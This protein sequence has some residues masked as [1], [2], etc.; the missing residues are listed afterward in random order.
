MPQPQCICGRR[1]SDTKYLR[2]HETACPTV[3]ERDKRVWEAISKPKESTSGNKRPPVEQ[4][5]AEMQTGLS[6]LMGRVKRKKSR[7][8]NPS[9]VA[10]GP[11]EEN[12]MVVVE[13]SSSFNFME[14][15]PSSLNANDEPMTDESNPPPNYL[16]LDVDEVMAALPTK[17]NRRP[18]ERARAML[19][20]NLPEGPGDL[21][22]DEEDGDMATSDSSLPQ[23]S[24]LRIRIRRIVKSV[25][26]KF[27]L[28]RTYHGRPSGVPKSHRSHFLAEDIRRA[29]NSTTASDP[30]PSKE[31]K[32]VASIIHPYPN[33]SAFLFNRW[34]WK[35]GKKTKAGRQDF[36]EEV[37]GHKDFNVDDIRD[38]DF[39]RLDQE[40]DKNPGGV[41]E[42]N[43]WS[44]STVPIYIPTVATIRDMGQ[45][46][47]PRCKVKKDQISAVGSS[48]DMSI[49]KLTARKDDEDRRER[50]R[51]ARSLIYDKGYVVNSSHVEDLIK[52]DSLVPTENAFSERLSKFGFNFFDM[53]VVDLMHEVE[54]AL[55][56]PAPAPAAAP[57]A[58]PAPVAAPASVVAPPVAASVS[59][60]PAPA[61][62]ATSDSIPAFSAS[63]SGKRA[64]FFN[65]ST[66]KA[67]FFPDYP[68]QIELLGTTDSLSTKVGE[69]RHTR[70]KGHNN[71]TNF[72]NA[73]PQIIGMD[74]RET[75]HARMTH[76]LEMLESH[77]RGGSKAFDSETDNVQLEELEKSF[78]IARD[79]KNKIYLPDFVRV[80]QSDP[81]FRNFLPRLKTHLLSRN[82][83]NAIPGE[84]P[85]F[86]NSE[87]SQVI[88]QNN[89]IFSHATASF[90]YTTYDVRRDQDTINVNSGRRD[91]MLPSFED[92]SDENNQ[93]NH[94][95]WY[96][97]I[98]G[99]YHAN[100]FFD[101][102]S[103]AERVDFL[104][105]RWLGRDMEWNSG[106]S[107]LRLDRIGFVSS[108]D[109]DAFGFLDPA[110]VIRACHLIPAFHW[111]T[112]I[113][114]LGPSTARD[115]SKGDWENYYVNRFVD[116]DMMMRY[117][118][119]GVGHCQ[120]PDFPREDGQL[121]RVPFGEFYPAFRDEEMPEG[122]PNSANSNSDSDSENEYEYEGRPSVGPRNQ[123]AAD[124][125]V[126]NGRRA[127]SSS[128]V[129]SG[130]SRSNSLRD[131]H[132]RLE[133]DNENHD[134]DDS[135]QEKDTSVENCIPDEYLTSKGRIIGRYRLMWKGFR[136][137]LEEGLLRDAGN[138][139][140]RHRD[141]S[142]YEDLLSLAPLV[143]DLVLNF[144]DQGLQRVAS[145]LDKARSKARASDVGSMKTH[146]HQWRKFEP[147]IVGN[148]S[149]RHLLGFHNMSSGRLLCPA[150]KNWDNI[151]IRRGL[152]DG[153]VVASPHDFPIFLWKDEKCS[154]TDV[155]N[156]F[157]QGEILLKAFLHIFI[158]PTSAYDSNDG[159]S[160]RKGNAAIHGIRAVSVYSI[161]YAATIVR[162]VLS[163]QSTL[164][165]GSQEKGRWPYSKFYT[166]LIKTMEEMVEEDL[167]DLLGW[168]ND[169]VFGDIDETDDEDDAEQATNMASMMR[170]QAKEKRL[171][172]AA[173]LQD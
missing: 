7:L 137:I 6:R 81:A 34:H 108:R 16:P 33:I 51:A 86:T 114:L 139:R 20:D 142:D 167:D 162:F 111:G 150:S 56:P 73:I 158:G 3:K 145:Q 154:S 171:R 116:R 118:G 121:K 169:T 55:A 62:A 155:F 57:Q 124:R 117:V 148:G 64:K 101:S 153:T 140:R 149:K 43:G 40:L 173:A 32:T 100:V 130:S 87:L 46:P 82:S 103:K 123:H 97:R 110:L 83:G 134:S 67:H 131:L 127:R 13:G 163:D 94:P 113:R 91:V 119:T 38:I 47:C 109:H 30:S 23:T 52:K 156:G 71:R 11:S 49:R 129:P 17:R 99:I 41:A 106:P 164:N 59:V 98:L 95:Y 12:M 115:S 60:P 18:T 151:D 80:N 72:N 68:G 26:N 19:E 28:V 107:N 22:S 85:K 53:I 44:N 170:A 92:S 50:V 157:L 66:P 15:P 125:R 161:A 2:S 25:A 165:A 27:G 31:R 120:P 166:A 70:L 168:W 63:G 96:A 76:E 37:I 93:D 65:L 147:P 152:Q 79:E 45:C 84:D 133:D 146:I 8:Q 105:V 88:V 112:S 5:P 4:E 21:Q 54:L 141:N 159:R 172:K 14:N 61:S 42:D 58:A 10:A 138:Q 69:S 9:E 39:N 74:I 90:N 35:G 122:P 160:T 135:D 24:P 78:H 143:P 126:R 136:P 128:P 132:N 77:S 75:V 89:F 104:F 144:G 29:E 36:L 102:K 48:S 1:F